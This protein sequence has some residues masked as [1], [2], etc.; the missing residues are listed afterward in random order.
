M[1]AAAVAAACTSG[2][3]HTDTPE[4]ICIQDFYL[5][6]GITQPHCLNGISGDTMQLQLKTK[7]SRSFSK[8]NS[9]LSK[10]AEKF[11]A[12]KREYPHINEIIQH[13]VEY[14]RVLARNH[15]AWPYISRKEFKS[16]NL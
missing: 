3:T 8:E 9:F 6:R 7:P 14:E 13:E 10:I 5:D 4:N 11:F 16:N 1:A 2:L 12:L 15:G